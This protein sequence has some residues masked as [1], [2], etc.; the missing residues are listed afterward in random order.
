MSQ[1]SAAPLRTTYWVFQIGSKLARSACGTKRNVRAAARCEIAG[2]ERAHVAVRAPAPAPVFK[3]AL[4]SMT[5]VF[6]CA[7][8]PIQCMTPQ[9]LRHLPFWGSYIQAMRSQALEEEVFW[10]GL[11]LARR[12]ARSRGNDCSSAISAMHGRLPQRV[13]SDASLPWL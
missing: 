7:A 11:L 6:L 8:V 4:R 9:G 5:I 1:I 2:I 12:N 10:P 13:M 3:N